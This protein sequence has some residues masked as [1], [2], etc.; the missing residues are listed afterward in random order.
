MK[1]KTKWTKLLLAVL[2][3]VVLAVCATACSKTFTV[4]FDSNGGSAVGIVEV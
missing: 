4:T 2:L 3:V 1:A